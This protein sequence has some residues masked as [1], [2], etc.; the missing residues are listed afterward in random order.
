MRTAEA[1]GVAVAVEKVQSDLISLRRDL[2]RH[3]E[4]GFAEER[5]ASLVAERMR[6]LGLSVRTGVGLSLIHI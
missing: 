1:H 6:S 3:P 5:T 4:L 2:H